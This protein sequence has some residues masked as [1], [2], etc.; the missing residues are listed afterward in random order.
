[1]D[2]NSNWEEVLKVIQ[3]PKV[4][5][6]VK[7][8]SPPNKVDNCCEDIRT[9]FISVLKKYEEKLKRAVG[10]SSIAG[11]AFFDLKVKN[12]PYNSGSWHDETWQN[13]DAVKT[14]SCKELLRRITDEYHYMVSGS[15]EFKR[16]CKK[17]NVDVTQSGYFGG[18]IPWELKERILFN[19]KLKESNWNIKGLDEE[20]WDL[21]GELE[22]DW[23]RGLTDL[24]GEV[25]NCREK[26]KK[27][28]G[29]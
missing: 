7:D 29:V 3:I 19:I 11:Q 25:R 17:I 5:L 24:I 8:L 28:G 16:R 20:S 13:I 12:T 27:S 18:V 6:N 14:L 21:L 9:Q 2:L 10:S 4:N 15:P 26:L 23:K 22:I 1:M